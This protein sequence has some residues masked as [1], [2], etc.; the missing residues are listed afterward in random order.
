MTLV[1]KNG[2][3]VL[4]AESGMPINPWFSTMLLHGMHSD[5]LMRQARQQAELVNRSSLCLQFEPCWSTPPD[6]FDDLTQWLC[7]LR[8]SNQISEYSVEMNF[9]WYYFSS[10]QC[11]TVQVPFFFL[12]FFL[13]F[14][15]LAQQQQSLPLGTYFN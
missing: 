12:F 4:V 1:N 10:F 15:L 8:V 3:Q 6:D 5:L 13:F 2:K 9:K 11:K 7:F 14:Y